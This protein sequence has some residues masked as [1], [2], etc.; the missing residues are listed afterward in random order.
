[1]LHCVVSYAGTK[2]SKKHCSLHFQVSHFVLL[3]Y[4]DNGDSWFLQDAYVHLPNY[5]AP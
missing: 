3:F 4:P 2:V 1:M 5:K